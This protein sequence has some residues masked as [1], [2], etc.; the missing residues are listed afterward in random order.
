MLAPAWDAQFFI[1]KFPLLF[2]HLHEDDGF[3]TSALPV[4]ANAGAAVDVRNRMDTGF[5]GG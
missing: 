2:K 1:S 5:A 3:V 4:S